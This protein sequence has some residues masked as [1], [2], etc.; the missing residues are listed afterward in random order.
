MCNTSGAIATTVSTSFTTG[1]LGVV[2][3]LH[4]GEHIDRARRR[5]LGFI[6]DLVADGARAGEVRGDVPA[7]ELAGYVL[8]AMSAAG[9]MHSEAAVRRLV[10]VIVAGLR[11]P[12]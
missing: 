7:D 10:T 6:A 8:G 2:V 5:L 12:R 3:R 4:Q 9:Q 11:P 1:G